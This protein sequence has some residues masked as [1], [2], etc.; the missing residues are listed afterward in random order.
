MEAL[1]GIICSK[2]SRSSIL[3]IALILLEKSVS[4]SLGKRSPLF[5]FSNTENTM[6][7]F[8][9]C[10]APTEK[11]QPRSEPII[12][13]KV[14]RF[15]LSAQGEAK[16][17]TRWSHPPG[18]QNLKRPDFRT[19]AK[20]RRTSKLFTNSRGEETSGQRPNT[21]WLRGFW[22]ARPDRSSRG[23]RRFPN[24]HVG[25]R[26]HRAVVNKPASLS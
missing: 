2:K 20:I 17:K 6:R 10:A 16:R 26:L 11:M 5:F 9:S 3:S 1:T 22:C 23:A 14:M 25:E 13:R 8:G 19:S 12:S 15:T 4:L 24:H 18:W 21:R 7:P